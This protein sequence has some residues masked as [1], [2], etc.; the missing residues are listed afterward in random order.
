MKLKIHRSFFLW[1]KNTHKG[2]TYGKWHKRGVRNINNYEIVI[3]ILCKY[4]GINYEEFKKGLKKKDKLYLTLLLMKKFRC[5]N[6]EV[7][8]E[9]LGIVSNRMLCYRMKKAEEKIL[10]NKKFR[11][12]YF[13]LE[14]KI[15]ENFKNA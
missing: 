5:L 12:E 10:I 8:E 6:E 4:Y 9:K 14:D 3:L 11:D 1:I 13:E 15:K 2:N 7:I